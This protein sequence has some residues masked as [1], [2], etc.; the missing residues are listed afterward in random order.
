MIYGGD[1][2]NKIKCEYCGNDTFELINTE[3]TPKYNNRNIYQLKCKNCDKV[4][5]INELTFVIN[6]IGKAKESLEGI[7]DDF[8]GIKNK[9]D[10]IDEIKQEMN[11]LNQTLEELT[12]VYNGKDTKV[13]NDL[14][15]TINIIKSNLPNSIIPEI[16]IEE[17][18]QSIL[19]K[20]SQQDNL[21]KIKVVNND[22]LIEVS[23]IIGNK[24]KAIEGC[25]FQLTDNKRVIE[26]LLELNNIINFK[27]S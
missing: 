3:E 16:Q 5:K 11:Q 19:L 13:R 18:Q 23:L 22:N 26:A 8:I 12:L 10:N 27:K 9:L 25:I 14:E 24:R 15:E 1:Y 2:L 4:S 21:G 7:I 6:E 20:N 17:N